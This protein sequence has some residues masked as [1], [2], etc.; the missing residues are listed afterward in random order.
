M[1]R[2]AVAADPRNAAV[3]AHHANFLA[4]RRGDAAAAA[5]AYE[6]CRAADPLNVVGLLGCA[7]AAAQAQ[8]AGGWGVGVG[9]R[10]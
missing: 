2:W 5:A 6:K 8:S 10:I 7:A 9:H 3:L 1:Y 4:V